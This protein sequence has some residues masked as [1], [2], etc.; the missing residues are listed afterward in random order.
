MSLI[1]R[2]IQTGTFGINHRIR[3]QW[4]PNRHV[5]T[6]TARGE[7]RDTRQHSG[8]NVQ[9]RLTIN[10]NWENL[11]LHITWKKS[12][13]ICASLYRFQNLS[14]EENKCE[15]FGQ[16]KVAEVSSKV[17]LCFRNYYQNISV[18]LH[19]LKS[20]MINKYE[21]YKKIEVKMCQCILKIQ[22]C[23]APKGSQ[24]EALPASYEWVKF[25]CKMLGNCSFSHEPDPS[26]TWT[27]TY[28]LYLQRKKVNGILGVIVHC[29]GNFS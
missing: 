25:F 14:Q 16:H 23:R 10:L 4:C 29:T 5:S 21:G 20:N 18:L 3:T 19:F 2:E 11:E 9:V 17:M 7:N 15:E 28:S 27:V 1:S 6:G 12:T 22:R 8:A 24:W 13:K 26:S